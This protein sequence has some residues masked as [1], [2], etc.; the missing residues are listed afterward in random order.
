MPDEVKA[1]FAARIEE[2]GP[3]AVKAILASIRQTEALPEAQA[4]EIEGPIG[5]KV[6]TSKDAIEE[7]VKR[8]TRAVRQHR[9]GV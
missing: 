4:F 8:G 9:P 2:N 6:F 3:L 7:F 5:A 1:Y